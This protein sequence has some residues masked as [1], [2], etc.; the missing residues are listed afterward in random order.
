MAN[1]RVQ[2]QQ[3]RRWRTYED[4]LE[5]RHINSY[6]KGTASS[7]KLLKGLSYLVI[8]WTTVILLGGF[9]SVLGKK[10]FWCLTAIT[11]VQLPG[12]FD[13]FHRRKLSTM[14][15]FYKN[16]WNEYDKIR[17]LNRPVESF[18][19]LLVMCVW[20]PCFTIIIVLPSLVFLW[21]GLYICTGVALWRLIEQDYGDPDGSANLRPALLVLYSLALLQGV[22][23]SILFYI[24]REEKRE[25]KY[26]A[27][28]YKFPGDEEGLI[29]N[30]AKETVHGCEKDMEF[31]KGRN[32]ITYSVDL[33]NSEAPDEVSSGV[34]ILGRLLALQWI[35]EDSLN[36]DR[37]GS[38]KK[39]NIDRAMGQ[40][41]LT[42]QLV[43]S[44]SSSRILHRLVHMLD[45]RC[46][47]DLTIRENAAMIVARLAGGIR[48]E[49]LPG[50][51][52]CI[53]SLI[54]EEYRDS[55]RLQPYFRDWVLE[56]FDAPDPRRP[57]D[58]VAGAADKTQD[59]WCNQ[60]LTSY[61]EMACQGLLILRKLARDEDN[62]RVMS[63]TKGLVSQIT[64][65]LRSLQLHTHHHDEWSK[66]ADATFR[67]LSLLIYVPDGDSRQKL[68]REIF[69]NTQAISIMERTV[70]NCD[71]CS[72]E[73]QRGAVWTLSHLFFPTL[74]SSTSAAGGHYQSRSRLIHL[75]ID[76]LADHNKRSD[77]RD[78]AAA[79]LAELSYWSSTVDRNCKAM[80]A[81]TLLEAAND[82]AVIYLTGVLL[83]QTNDKS[84][85]TSAAAILHNLTSH[86]NEHDER[87]EKLKTSMITDIMPKVLR[88]IRP[89]CYYF[90]GGGNQ[91]AAEEV[92]SSNRF[93][94]PDADL[95]NAHVSQ[96]NNAQNTAPSRQQDGEQHQQDSKFMEVMLD[97][98]IAVHKKF[99]SERQDQI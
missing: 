71:R 32:L 89:L 55:P 5:V 43:G 34:R 14:L 95:E 69:N 40:L 16:I 91:T 90:A 63:N 70:L 97:L 18:S 59:H 78:V 79:E 93:S 23:Y 61:T 19:F 99:I 13:V 7:L 38:S 3:N 15:S 6:A 68:R 8:T 85:R 24:S 58:M 73:L 17:V 86:Y 98:S 92:D 75:L 67:L 9:V 66:M 87:F 25:V 96:D 46:P 39:K 37:P 77:T 42:K 84:L 21:M 82:T 36:I 49:Q 80:I 94:P 88:E 45:P 81:Y 41:I 12:V 60:S 33:I 76:I 11:L 2:E 51:I 62:C 10:D 4:W 53:T 48:L 22:V 65:P 28:R 26:V 64:A 1:E 27:Q 35:D 83:L 29:L 54:S 20:V 47:Y 31:S 52:H 44:T 74:L 30:Y 57:E 50:G 56:M 72:A